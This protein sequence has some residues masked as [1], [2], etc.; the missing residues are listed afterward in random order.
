MKKRRKL[1]IS[2]AMLV[3]FLLAV[4]AFMAVLVKTPP[5]FYAE[6]QLPAGEDREALSKDL[7]AVFSQIRF[8]LVNDEPHWQASFSS[9]QINAFFQEDFVRAGADD[10]LPEGFHEPR[11]QIQDGRLRLGVRYGSGFWSTILSL[12]LKMWLVSGDI[13]M[14]AVEI[15]GLNAGRLP[16]STSTLLDYITAM[17]RQQNIDVTW[18]RSEGHP[19]AI[20]RF[21]ADQTRPTFQFERVELKDQELVLVGRSTESMLTG[22][23]RGA[24]KP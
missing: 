8:A 12:E 14:L 10:N 22:A 5:K 23:L 24:G 1:L 7:L 16:L 2:G 18:Y 19:V 3:S 17:S 9:D 6:S 4:L 11:L 15:V 20:M 21:Q 13:N